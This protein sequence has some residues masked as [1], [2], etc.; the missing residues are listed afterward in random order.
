MHG[1][2][3]ATTPYT[4]QDGH[5]WGL[6]QGEVAT[7]GGQVDGLVGVH[8]PCAGAPLSGLL[9]PSVAVSMARTLLRRRE[10]VVEGADV[11]LV[12]PAGRQCCVEGA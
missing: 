8:I 1:I 2:K 10:G 5:R 7:Q 3:G 12:G 9:H 4:H 11:R 6:G